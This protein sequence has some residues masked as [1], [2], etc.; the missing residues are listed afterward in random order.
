MIVQVLI[1]NPNSWMW[2]YAKQLEKVI[3][4][5]GFHS[6]FRSSVSQVTK[7]DYL[8]LLSCEKVIPKEVLALNEYNLVIHAA[9]LPKGRGFSPL[10]YQ[11]LEGKND[12]VVSLIEA[13]LKVDEGQIY[14]QETLHFEGHELIGEMRRALY[15]CI[16]NFVKVVLDYGLPEG[17]AQ[18]GEPSYYERRKPSE[19]ELDINKPLIEQFNL[20]R[21]V[22]NECYPAFFIYKNCKYVLKVEKA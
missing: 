5:C 21:V 22:D 6:L 20:L 7:G 12:I 8:F 18:C 2:D 1:D 16:A 14:L 4:D 11:V 3:Y 13:A 17:T 10:T 9:D 19:S 15:Y